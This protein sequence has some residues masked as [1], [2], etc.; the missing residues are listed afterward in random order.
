MRIFKK[1]QVHNNSCRPKH[2]RDNSP[3]RYF[4]SFNHEDGLF[5]LNIQRV[6]NRFGIII[7]LRVTYRINLQIEV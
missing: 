6:L 3:H 4:A 2:I 7:M 5:E 1:Y